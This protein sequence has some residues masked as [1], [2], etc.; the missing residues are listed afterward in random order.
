MLMKMKQKYAI[1]SEKN[2]RTLVSCQCNFYL[3]ADFVEN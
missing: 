2:C 1:E 3:P